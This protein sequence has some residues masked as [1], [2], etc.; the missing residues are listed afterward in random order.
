M[1]HGK[2]IKMV[3][4][5]TGAREG[6]IGRLLC[7]GAWG[8]LLQAL[9]QTSVP[10]RFPGMFVLQRRKSQHLAGSLAA[11]TGADM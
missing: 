11:P 2:T 1:K 8:F 9:L 7:L 10:R 4:T 5:G 3:A 6:V